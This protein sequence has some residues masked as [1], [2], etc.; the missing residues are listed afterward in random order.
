MLW[1]AR[2]TTRFLVS[3]HL[4]PVTCIAVGVVPFPVARWSFFVAGG[5]ALRALRSF[6]RGDRFWVAMDVKVEPFHWIEVEGCGVNFKE[7]VDRSV[8]VL[9]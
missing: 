5:R 6:L 1:W 4:L 2:V 9:F 8:E 3:V 7:L